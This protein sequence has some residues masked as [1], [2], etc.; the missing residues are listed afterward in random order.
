MQR[1]TRDTKT[2]LF[3]SESD[4]FAFKN[5]LYLMGRTV[6]IPL[7]SSLD[8][9]WGFRIL[10]LFDYFTNYLLVNE[11]LMYFS[12]DFKMNGLFKKILIRTKL[13]NHIFNW[14]ILN[15]LLFYVLS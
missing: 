11:H 15:F 14:F 7:T 1:P 5:P 10:K 13:F 2:V 8:L 9:R 6:P 3:L 12:C 4:Y